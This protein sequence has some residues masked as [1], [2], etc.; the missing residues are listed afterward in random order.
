MLGC[1]QAERRSKWPFLSIWKDQNYNFLM[2]KW[3]QFYAGDKTQALIIKVVIVFYF[4]RFSG[5]S[6]L[7]PTCLDGWFTDLQRQRNGIHCKDSDLAFAI[8]ISWAL[9]CSTSQPSRWTTRCRLPMSEDLLASLRDACLGPF[10]FAWLLDTW[11]AAYCSHW[12]VIQNAS[13]SWICRS[14]GNYHHVAMSQKL[15]VKTD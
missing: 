11:I 14:E 2:G 4:L 1:W 8:C 6:Q 9:P 10:D 5:T 7:H 13:W 12:S 3:R 15:E